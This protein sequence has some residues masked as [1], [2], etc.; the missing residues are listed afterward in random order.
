MLLTG[1]M[2]AFISTAH[3]QVVY[4][5]PDIDLF[6]HSHAATARMSFRDKGPLT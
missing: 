4:S 2:L 3:A 6:T 1:A 5:P